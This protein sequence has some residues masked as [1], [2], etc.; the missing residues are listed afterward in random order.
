MTADAR[1]LG[2]LDPQG[3]AEELPAAIVV[4]WERA[5]KR[6]RQAEAL[7]RIGTDTM[8]APD[9]A[10]DLAR[11]VATAPVPVVCRVDGA[12]AGLADDVAL[13]ASCGAAVVLVPMVRRL[14]ELEVALDAAPSG[15]RVATMIETPEAVDLAGALADLPL[16]FAY[17]GLMDL[18]LA[19][20][21]RTIFSA[22]VDG[23]VERVAEACG[24]TV[25]LGVA[26]LTVPGGGTPLPVGLLHGELARLGCALSF[27]RRSFLRDVG[28]NPLGPAIAAIRAD[29]AAAA[30]RTAGAVARDRAAFV[31]AVRALEHAP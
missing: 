14:A 16:A 30:A 29:A 1:A 7:A 12:G 26:G 4:D 27:L 21:S 11:V 3:P 10:D 5:G 18:A 9:T 13:A 15:T 22:L 2:A 28:G 31:E 17:V 19:R 23:T 20:Q 25:P 8:I 24:G 6:H